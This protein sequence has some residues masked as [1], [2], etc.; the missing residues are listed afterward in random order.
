MPNLAHT[1]WQLVFHLQVAQSDIL[2]FCRDPR[3]VSPEYP[4]GYWPKAASPED[5]EQWQRTIASFREDLQAM[6][7]LVKDPGNDLFVPFAHGSGQNLLRETILV[8]A[9]FG[10]LGIH[11]SAGRAPIAANRNMQDV[12]MRIDQPT[13]ILM[14]TVVPSP[15]AL[16]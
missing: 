14:V 7:D 15:G 2:E 8:V 6:A 5:E 4:S 12:T 3:H 1:A 11:F 13:G 10:S 16:R 9:S